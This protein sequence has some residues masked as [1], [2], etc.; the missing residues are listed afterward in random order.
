M[1]TCFVIQPFDKGTFD[2]RYQ[3]IIVPAIQA[4][5]LEPYRVD[6]DPS[7]EILI[8]EI[9]NGIR[10]ARIC[11]AEITTNNPNVWYEL[12][13]A[14]A[15]GK[16]VVLV[17]AEERKEPF[18][19][20]VQ[21]RHILQY[22]TESSSDFENMKTKISERIKALLEKEDQFRIISESSPI[23]RTEGLSQHEIVALASVMQNQVTPIDHVYTNVIQRSMFKSGYTEIAT[24]L[25]IRALLKK[26]L[27][28]SNIETD[29]NG[30][31]TSIIQLTPAGESWLQDNIDRLVIKR[32]SSGNSNPPD[33]EDH[34]DDIPF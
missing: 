18:P 3:D 5:G 20:D 6:Q 27:I 23:A 31:E 21:H 2:K 14:L 10:R 7:V 12:G 1:D 33:S 13:F 24:S 29:F 11:L 28:S 26:N 30:N 19:F 22:K 9:E 17:C 32:P 25:A 16:S 15:S 8:D 4:T 34:E